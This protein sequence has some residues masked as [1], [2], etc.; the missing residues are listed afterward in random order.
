MIREVRQR[1]GPGIATDTFYL[2]GYSDVGQFAL[3]FLYLHSERLLAA[4]IG[5]SGSITRLD[6]SSPWPAGVADT[7]SLVGGKSTLMPFERLPYSS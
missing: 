6:T 4:S 7:A 2:A 1:W 3:R 5:A